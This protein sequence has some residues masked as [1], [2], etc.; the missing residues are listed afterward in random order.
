MFV[1]AH[2]RVSHVMRQHA[3]FMT[4]PALSSPPNPDN[5]RLT[6]GG[7]TCQIQWLIFFFPIFLTLSIQPL[8]SLCP[9]SDWCVCVCVVCRRVW[10]W[11]L[12]FNYSIGVLKMS[13]GQIWLVG[14]RMESKLTQRETACFPFEKGHMEPSFKPVSASGS[15]SAGR[16]D[17]LMG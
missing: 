13:I 4:L 3:S 16:V 15:Y 10:V 14:H 11:V 8:N 2:L 9:L 5:I 6:G 17:I 12:S 1:A 7:K